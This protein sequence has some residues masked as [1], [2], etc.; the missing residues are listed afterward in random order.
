MKTV[1]YADILGMYQKDGNP[2]LCYALSNAT[3]GYFDTKEFLRVLGEDAYGPVLCKW[4]RRI[5][6][7]FFSSSVLEG[8]YPGL[9]LVLHLQKPSDEEVN[10]AGR[11]RRAFRIAVL[12]AMAKKYPDRTFQYPEYV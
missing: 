4:I 5:T 11:P 12:T 1:T 3:M 8:M 9:K 6:S 2:F 10:A 7:A